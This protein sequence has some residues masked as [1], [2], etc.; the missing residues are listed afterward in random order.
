MPNFKMVHD[1]EE[2]EMDT[3]RDRERAG[4]KETRDEINEK[5]Q[6]KRIL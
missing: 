2:I 4:E 3:T 5:D 1:S 6:R